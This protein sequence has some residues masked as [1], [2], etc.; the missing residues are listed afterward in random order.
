MNSNKGGFNCRLLFHKILNI[1]LI[2]FISIC[3]W[4]MFQK[5]MEYYKNINSYKEIQLE[6]EQLDIQN[7]LSKYDCD[8][9]TIND[10]TIDYPI[11]TYTDNDYYMYHNYKG[12]DDV[13]GAI[14]YDCYDEPYNGN[15]TIIYGHSMRNGTMFNNLHLFQKDEQKFNNSILTINTKFKETEYKPLGYYVTSNDFFYRDLD[16][17]SIIEAVNV[18]KEKSDCFIEETNIKE[19]AHIIALY[20]CDYS[21]KDGKL[22]VFYVSE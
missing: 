6:K 8:W 13:G 21:I 9:I 18:I 7:V 22:I 14:F 17:V 1:I 2:A 15:F 11:M 19:N 5:Q 16:D 20:T 10:T 12:E 3:L 4:E